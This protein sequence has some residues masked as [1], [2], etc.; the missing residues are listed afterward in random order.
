MVFVGQER[1]R[2]PHEQPD[3]AGKNQHVNEERRNLVP[4]HVPH[5]ALV[6]QYAT[7]E[8]AV[9]P[10][11]ETTLGLAVRL[12]V[13]RLE[14][15]GAQGRGEDQRNQYRQRHGRND[16]DGELFVDHTGGAAEECHRQQYR[17]QH[18]GNTHQGALDLA[19]GLD[20]R[21]FRRQVLLG[22]H[23]LDVLHHDDGVVHQQAD[24]QDHAEHGQGVDGEAERGQDPEGTQQYHRYSH[25]GDDGGAEVLQEQEH[26]QEHQH[27]RL[28]QGV[29]HTGNRF[30][31]HWS[32]VI[33]HHRLH[34]WREERFQG[35]D[36]G[37]DGL[38]GV[39]G[40]GA[41]GQLDRHTGRRVAVELRAD[42]V[43]LAAQLD[44]RDVLQA[45]L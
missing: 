32:G 2:D 44:T 5:A 10:A 16:G 17:R 4:D 15:G 20:R 42:A 31:H 11:E 21:L 27:D 13:D 22:H 7:V 39:Q 12:G 25:G 9:E 19:H 41:G 36:R 28:D 33:R 35:R 29:Y 8:G 30:G 34:A 6:A 3:H 37:T 23:P 45:N 18:Q 26:H 1:C 14:H 24:G 40:V 38:G 43:G